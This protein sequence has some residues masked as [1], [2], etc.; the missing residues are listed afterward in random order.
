MIYLVRAGLCAGSGR[1]GLRLEPFRQID[2]LLG[3]KDVFRFFQPRAAGNDLPKSVD[4]CIP[5]IYLLLGGG[6]LFRHSVNSSI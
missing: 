1:A 6:S 5:A 4:M 3:L 2:S